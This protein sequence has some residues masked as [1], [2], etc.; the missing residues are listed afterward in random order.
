MD[1]EPVI[2]QD[3]ASGSADEIVQLTIA[4]SQG[5]AERVQSLAQHLSI[6]QMFPQPEIKHHTNAGL[7]AVNHQRESAVL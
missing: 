1:P 2:K 5:N 7:M 4:Q 3:N 6:P